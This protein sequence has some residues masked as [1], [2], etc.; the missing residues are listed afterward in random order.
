[1]R[2]SLKKYPIDIFLCIIWSLIIL[3]FAFLNIQGTIR[4]ILGLPIILFIPGYLLIFV[5]FPTKKE[6]NG[7]DVLERI[8]LSFGLSIV[9]I[10][11]IGLILNYTPLGIR[12]EPILI[13]LTIFILSTGLIA[14]FR[15]KKT[16][17]NERFTI[18]FEF[19]LFKTDKKVEK[20]LTTI[21]VIS[22]LIATA[23][24]VYAIVTPK[25]GEEFT[26]FYILGPEGKADNYPKNL[27]IGEESSVIIG[28]ANHEYKQ[29]SYS[30][31]IW[32]INQSVLKNEV[33]KENNTIINQAWFMDNISIKLNHKPVDI[34]GSWT[35]QWN[36]NYDFSINKK[37]ENFKLTFLLFTSPSEEAY[38]KE[39]DYKDIIEEKIK[40]AYRKNHLY[41]TVI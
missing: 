2:I 11:I 8:A 3:P 27:T 5:L 9:I 15:W 31:E 40:S 32:L 41:L 36:Y 21:L 13:F 6:E 17:Q 14:I 38:E 39:T 34:E 33:T 30:I 12:L 16:Q 28:L 24:I 26:E 1:M 20:V 22:I 35:A 4:V 29:V 19:S 10:P 18:S 25:R 37:G 23:S 7:I